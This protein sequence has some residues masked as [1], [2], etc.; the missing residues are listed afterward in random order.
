MSKILYNDGKWD[1]VWDLPKYQKIREKIINAFKGLVFV[2]EGHKYF[3]NGKEITCVS[4]VTHLFKPEFDV[5]ERAKGCYNRYYNDETSQY[6][7]MSVEQIKE[8]WRIN[9]K[10]ACEHGTQRHEF[11]ESCFYYMTRQYD[12][13]LPEF[14]DRLREDGGFEALYPK[15]EAAVKFYESMP[16]CIIP[17]LAE[18]KVYDEDLGY[19]GTF[20]LLCYYDAELDGRDAEKSGLMVLD[21]KTNKDLFKNFNGQTLLPPF[22]ELL[23]MPVSIYK[24][25]LSLYQNCLEKIG[26]KVIARRLM[27]LKPDGSCDKIPL[28]EYVDR[29][30]K[31]L[32]NMKF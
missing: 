2:E 9:S 10:N 22:D 15:E 16:K 7:G 19:S 14:K 3:L 30:R 18:T 21:W 17:I 1:G 29:L 4:N 20:D 23:D 28:E 24:L 12:K 27:W 25:Q 13:I 11:S 32:A 5:E 26:M 31:A 8:A 6:Y